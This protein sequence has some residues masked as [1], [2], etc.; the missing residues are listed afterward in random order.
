M[1]PRGWKCVC[2]HMNELAHRKCR[3][4]GCTRSRRK[5]PVRAHMKALRDVTYADYVA[6]AVAI[7]GVTD[8]SCC[9][10]GKPRSQERRHDRDH[11]HRMSRPRGLACG[12]NQGCNVLMLPWVT[13]PAA[14]GI[15]E[16]KLAAG[17]PDADRWR[18]IAEYLER[19]D[20]YYAQEAAA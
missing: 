1:A 13:A 3:G 5:R 12:G 16:A 6:L 14:R 10:C 19:V 17:E 9:V 20:A 18:L 4:A 2:G 8:E 15:A 7:H 11:D